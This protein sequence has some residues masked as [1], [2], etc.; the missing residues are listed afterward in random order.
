VLSTGDLVVHRNVY[1]YRLLS[2]TSP[3]LSAVSNHQRRRATWDIGSRGVQVLAAFAVLVAVV[4]AVLAWQA[5]PDVAPVAKTAAP[6]ASAIAGVAEVVVAVSGKV[7]RPGLVRV[8]AG[9]RVADAIEAA[10]GVLPGTDISS[11]NLA[12]KVTDGELIAV[13]VVASPGPS[14]GSGG[15]GSSGGLVNLNTATLEQLQTLPGVGPVLGQHIVDYRTQHG[16]F[17]SVAELRNVNGIGDVRFNDLKS[18]VTV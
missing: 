16:G 6:P 15:S 17:K 7:H 9:A 12:R 4:A 5:R 13:G 1:T 11:L 8:P 14:G 18:R 3:S 10:G 2:A